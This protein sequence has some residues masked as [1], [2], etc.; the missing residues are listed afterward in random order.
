MAATLWLGGL[1]AACDSG[2][3]APLVPDEEPARGVLAYLTWEPDGT[4]SFDT[5]DVRS[6]RVDRIAMI[7]NPARPRFERMIPSPNLSRAVYIWTTPDVTHFVIS[8]LDGTDSYDLTGESRGFS[9]DRLSWSPN[10]S[11]LMMGGMFMAPFVYDFGPTNVPAGESI[12]LAC[13][14]LVF[15]SDTLQYFRGASWGDDSDHIVIAAS[16]KKDEQDAPYKSTHL[17]LLNV[18]SGIIEQKLTSVPMSGLA[19]EI[20]RGGRAAVALRGDPSPGTQTLISDGGNRVRALS[21]PPG[22]VPSSNY[23]TKIRWGGDGRHVLLYQDLA[24]TPSGQ[25]AHFSIGIIDTHSEDL[26]W[27]EKGFF[28]FDTLPEPVLLK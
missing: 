17:Y 8:N 21:L 25:D 1:L 5:R 2:S 28:D 19:F 20:A 4:A 26:L 9:G 22:Y 16:T 6:G 7:A 18:R 14:D 15:Q 10:G 27:I 3:Q 23:S 11:S 12:C 24:V 13:K